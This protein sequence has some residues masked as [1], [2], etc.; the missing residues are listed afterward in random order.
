M[1]AFFAE[2]RRDFRLYRLGKSGETILV[3]KRRQLSVWLFSIFITNSDTESVFIIDDVLF[4]EPFQIVV[5]LALER[6]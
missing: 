1:L 3:G 2:E 6:L 4:N 5:I